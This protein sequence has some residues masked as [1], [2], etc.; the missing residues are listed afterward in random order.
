MC[1]GTRRVQLGWHLPHKRR[2]PT[3]GVT[4]TPGAWNAANT[5]DAKGVPVTNTH[6]QDA[7]EGLRGVCALEALLVRGT[8]VHERA[9]RGVQV[10]QRRDLRGVCAVQQAPRL[11]IGVGGWVGGGRGWGCTQPNSKHVVGTL[12]QAWVCQ[13]WTESWGTRDEGLFCSVQHWC[14]D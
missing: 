11:D 10:N 12:L 3:Q 7:V 2:S 4:Q 8:R 1:A 14:G 13:R 5:V 6:A 9:P